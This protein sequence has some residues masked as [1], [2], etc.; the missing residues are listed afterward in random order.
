MRQILKWIIYPS[1]LTFLISSNHG[2]AAISAIDIVK[3]VKSTYQQ[4]KTISVEFEQKSE[5]KL[6]GT[7]HSITGKMQIKDEVKF[8]I[9]MPDLVTV[10]DGTNIWN[11][12]KST[13]Q[14]IINYVKKSDTDQ[15]PS[16][17]LLQY[18]ERYH[19]KLIGEEKLNQTD[20]YV[21]ELTSKTG[22]DYIQQMKIWI[23]KKNWF[24][25]KVEQIDIHGNKKIFTMN[26]INT[27]IPIDDSVF[28]YVTPE[29]VEEIDMRR[30]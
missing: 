9:E 5:W 22:N 4:F 2:F 15:L 6:A 26:V 13:N 25:Q 17:L 10:S 27:D 1:I 20:C 29:G 23:A 14:V 21:L 28:T 16:K 18:S 8:R 24:T 3:K 30:K 19:A 7:S 12:S 11:Y